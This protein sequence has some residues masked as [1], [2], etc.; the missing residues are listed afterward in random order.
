MQSYSI[1]DVGMKRKVNQDFVYRCEH[2]IGKLSNLFIVADGMGGHNAG[3]YASKYCVESVIHYIE[4]SDRQTSI[5]ILDG[6][7]H[8]ANQNL[9][10]KACEISELEGMGTTL[11]A[12]TIEENR[13]IVANIGDSRLY[14]INEQIKQ[15]TKDHSLVQIMVENGEISPE[16]AKLHPNKNIITRAIGGLDN[17]A[18]ADFFEV[19]LNVGDIVLLCSDGLSNMLTDEDI[20][21]VIKQ[22]SENLDK[23]C[24]AL[25][26][27]AN[28][29][30]GKDNIAI[31]LMKV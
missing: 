24:E 17:N 16:D 9:K 31:I 11:V 2:E 15:I 28:T 3:D 25:V 4:T 22:L 19:D 6:A 10:E 12:A 8:Y 14:V 18:N 5:S 21:Q 1:T 13:M 27:Q 7:I 30:G 23:A 26:E 20:F 29:L